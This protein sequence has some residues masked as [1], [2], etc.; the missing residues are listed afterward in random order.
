MI[1][2]DTKV[3][4]SIVGEIMLTP[5][6]F[7]YLRINNIYFQLQCWIFNT[8][9]YVLTLC[10]RMSWERV[11][12]DSIRVEEKRKHLGGKLEA[13][14]IWGAK[15][16]ILLEGTQA[17]PA[18]PCDKGRMGVKTLRWWVVK[19]W[20]RDGRILFHN[21]L[22]SVDIIWKLTNFVALEQGGNFDEFT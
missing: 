12:K 3:T 15:K 10:R 4:T 5:N 13:L 8:A 17:M 18:R 2:V 19:A 1:N 7:H 21:S 6:R 11:R 20:E 14:Y 9:A 16:S 22:L